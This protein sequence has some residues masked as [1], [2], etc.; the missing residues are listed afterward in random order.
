MAQVMRTANNTVGSMIDLYR[1]T[2]AER[3][4]V[5]EAR[6]ITR[7]VFEDAFGWDV[8]QLEDRRAQGLS[9]S[10]WLKVNGVLKGLRKGEPMQYV[11]GHAWFMGMRLQVSP[12]VLIPRP[13]TEELVDAI[14]KDRF[15]PKRVLDIGTGSG[16]IAIAL[17]RH[18][19]HTE[20][21]GADISESALRVANA[22]A[23]QVGVDIHWLERDVLDPGVELPSDLDLIVSNPPYIPNAE[24]DSL[25]SHV[26][27]HEPHV[28]LF[29][30]DGDPLLFYRRIGELGRSALLPGGALW[31]EG[32]HLFADEVGSMLRELGYKDVSVLID[33]SGSS[34]F[35]SA[36]R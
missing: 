33:L 17:K 29:V 16:C 26:R 20:V 36:H 35:I 9:E 4:G 15:Q 34:R 10:E 12:E 18:W 31:F 5:E 8:A 22:N 14:C 7:A 25:A 19:P 1:S 30:D 24:A 28:A 27:D 23:K 13:E 2:L 11:L 21:Y 32:H 6:A 3:F